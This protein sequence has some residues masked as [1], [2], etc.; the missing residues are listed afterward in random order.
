[1]HIHTRG[2]P[3]GR[4]RIPGVVGLDAQGNPRGYQSRQ[5]GPTGLSDSLTCEPLSTARGPEGVADGQVCRPL[6]LAQVPAASTQA[7]PLTPVRYMQRYRHLPVPY[8]PPGATWTQVLRADVHVYVN[9]NLRDETPGQNHGRAANME[10]KEELLRHMRAERRQ[11]SGRL[12]FRLDYDQHR[13]AIAHTFFGVGSPEE[14]AITLQYALAFGLTLPGTLANYCD[15]DPKVGVDCVGFVS[16]FLKAIGRNRRLASMNHLGSRPRRETN[17]V[18]QPQDILFWRSRDGGR[19]RFRHVAIIDSVQ[20]TQNQMTVVE[21]SG[22]FE[23]LH[24]GTYTILGNNNGIFHVDRG[25]DCA[26]SHRS[27]VTIHRP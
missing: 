5:R 4:N 16:N 3:L 14:C 15:H 18:I 1:M 12:P 11:P 9:E 2:K 13:M 10:R 6:P 8:S 7:R 25:A 17:E 27:Y 21:S 26:G 22:S 23:G 24:A 20:P 19:A